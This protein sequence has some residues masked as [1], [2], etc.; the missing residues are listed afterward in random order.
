MFFLGWRCLIG[1][2]M[3]FGLLGGGYCMFV[4]VF[5]CFG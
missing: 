1:G 4:D 3:G 2:P 5:G